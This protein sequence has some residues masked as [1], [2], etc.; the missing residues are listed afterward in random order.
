VVVVSGRFIED[1]A[2]VVASAASGDEAA[3]AS[4]VAAYHEDMRR[5]CVVVACDDRIAEDAVAAAWAIA[6]RKIGSLRDP[7]L[8]RPWL[9]SVA[10][11]EARQLLRARRRRSLIEVPV[12]PRDERAGSPDP[13]SVVGL[14]DLRNALA[15]LEPGDRALLA[16]RYLAGFDATELA[17]ATGRSPSGTRARLA[18]LLHRLEKELGDG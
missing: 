18:R 7:D 11:N 13:A 4:I 8:L 15:R 10:V 12:D 6:W 1:A 16:M 9:V 17:H 14:I 2:S 3:F 5:V